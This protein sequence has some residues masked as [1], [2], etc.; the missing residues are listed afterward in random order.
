MQ[1]ATNAINNII[2]LLSDA[3]KNNPQYCGIT[4]K[5]IARL[6]K[7]FGQ[8][9]P[10]KNDA[11]TNA[12]TMR[13]AWIEAEYLAHGDNAGQLSDMDAEYA[14]NHLSRTLLALDLH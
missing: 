12:A 5:E 7:G 4:R 13:D 6:I 1:T 11:N 3:I 9:A 14:A 8:I 10:Y 2:N